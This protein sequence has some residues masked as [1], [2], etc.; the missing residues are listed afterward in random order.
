MWRKQERESEEEKGTKE[1]KRERND[2]ENLLRITRRVNLRTG[3]V[4][5][6]CATQEAT[7]HAK[8]RVLLPGPDET[9]FNLAAAGAVILSL[10]REEVIS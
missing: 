5:S 9:A 7:V 2:A 8:R 4:S 6:P 1:G 10:L 3:N